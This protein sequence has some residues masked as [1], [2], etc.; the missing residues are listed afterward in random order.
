MAAR[1]CCSQCQEGEGV[2]E[3]CTNSTDTVCVK[4]PEQTYSAKT[5]AG[6]VAKRA[7][8]AVLRASQRLTLCTNTRYCLRILGCGL[9]FIY[10]FVRAEPML[11]MLSLPAG[12]GG[13]PLRG[14]VLLWD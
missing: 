11:E 3:R 2:K 4:C 12:T 7:H 13:D 10:Q 6:R 14:A 9:V 8:C 5:E 1:K